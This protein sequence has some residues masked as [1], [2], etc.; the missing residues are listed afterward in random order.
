MA[1]ARMG[2]QRE[3]AENGGAASDELR[4]RVAKAP[5]PAARGRR[6]RTRETVLTVA[7]LF[8]I[9]VALAVDLATSIGLLRFLWGPR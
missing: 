7:L 3:A 1:A 9:I 4:T 2:A 5:A 6:P 8:A